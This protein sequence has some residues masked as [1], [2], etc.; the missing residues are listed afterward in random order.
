MPFHH[1]RKYLKFLNAIR[2]SNVLICKFC[3]KVPA[4]PWVYEECQQANL[5][6]SNKG[7]SLELTGKELQVIPARE[8]EDQPLNFTLHLKH[9]SCTGT[10]CTRISLVLWWVNERPAVQRWLKPMGAF[11]QILSPLVQFGYLNQ[12]LQYSRRSCCLL[13]CVC[14]HPFLEGQTL[15]QEWFGVLVAQR[16][17]RERCLAKCLHLSLGSC[18][19][20]CC[21]ETVSGL[22]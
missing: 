12:R 6:G 9:S 7:Q 18:R 21:K 1:K 11:L 2:Q 8:S 13:T 16:F 14:L 4:C 15:T 20:H 10:L 19:I 17:Q 5:G 3:H 22:D